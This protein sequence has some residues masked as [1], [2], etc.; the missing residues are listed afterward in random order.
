MT[1]DLTHWGHAC[2]RLERDGARLVIDPGGFTDPSVLDDADAVLVTHQHEDHVV[3]TTLA[4]HLAGRPEVQVWAPAAVVELLA[5]AGVPAAQLHTAAVGDTFEAAG[6]AV[7][8]VGEQHAVVHPDI[9]RIANVGYLVDGALLHPGDA[10]TVPDAHVEVLLTPVSGPWIKVAE[11]VDYVRA[12]AP[13]LVVPIHDGLLNAAGNGLVDRLVGGMGG[14]A[15]RRLD[16]GETLTVG[17]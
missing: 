16:A 14:A 5:A 2:V 3:P 6:F 9:P 7:R 15:Y 17:V 12:V 4:E 13:D 11:S 10:L 1:F 8:V